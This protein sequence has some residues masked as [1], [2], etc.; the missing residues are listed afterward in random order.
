MN[1][2]CKRGFLFLLLLGSG[3]FIKAQV[4]INL[5]LPPS[6]LT[7]KNQLWNFSL[8][9]TSTTAINVK[10]EIIFQDASN[11]QQ[12]FTGTSKMISLDKG[13]K[14]VQYSDVLPVV[15]TVNNSSYGVDASPDGFLPIGVFS[16]CFN[17]IQYYSDYTSN[18]AQECETIEIEP[19]S[20]PILV[21]PAD[22]ERV[23]LTRP[24]FTWTPP[25]PFNLFSNLQY[26]WVLVEVQGTQTAAVALQQNFPILNQVG[27]NTSS[28]QY[29]LS[30]PELDTSKLYAWQVSAKNNG[31][32]IAQS[33]AWTFRVMKFHPDT[34][35]YQRLGFFFKLTKEMDPAYGICEGT[36][37]YEYLNELN[38]TTVSIRLFD[39]SQ[40]SNKEVF[41]DNASPTLKYGQNFIK[42]DLSQFSAMI[43]KHI[44]L[45]SLTN[46][47][48]ENW[49]MK[50][51][52]HQPGN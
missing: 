4:L 13:I 35:V 38:D 7:V 36:V 22:S 51:E 48:G 17:V 43:D 9:N 19:I 24:F 47:K 18:I 12:V 27:L 5:Q 29:P 21:T 30:A 49:Y 1:T 28:F 8:I 15:Y 23:E 14:Q 2:I 33:E 42:W 31:L 40:A 16:V 6:G 25:I 32:P 50:F 39:V 44:Y 26:D 20:P 45:F 11:N 52:Y 37:R 41:P 10:V 46:S 3:L 34:T